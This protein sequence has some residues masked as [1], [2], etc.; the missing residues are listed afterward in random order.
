MT[1]P[2]NAISI[3]PSANESV[4]DVIDRVD[5]NRRP[6]MKGGLGA[7]T[8][9][10]FG[11][12][13]LL[14]AVRGA[15]AATPAPVGGIG[16]SSIA[17][18][19]APG[20]FDGVKVLS[21]YTAKIFSAWGDPIGHA[22]GSP[23]LDPNL[24]Q[25]EANQNKQDGMHHDGMHFFAFPTIGAGGVSN[26]RGLLV[27]NHEYT[28]EGI[29]RNELTPGSTPQNINRVRTSQA[30]HGVSVKEV[31]KV[32]GHWIVQRPSPFARRLTVNTPIKSTGPAAGHALMKTAYINENGSPDG[33]PSGTSVKGTLNNCAHGFTPW[34]TYLTCEENFN[35]YFAST[36]APLA[37]TP[38]EY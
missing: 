34:G 6:F 28:D 9:T 10:A 4:R 20:M 8:L 13:A 22:S 19:L 1:H 2:V 25:T 29:L 18:S 37:R 38:L 27:T 32:A 21:G 7:A 12:E 11:G 30:G 15:Y 31:R 33:D 3:N 24:P 26:E 23:Q 36:E 5:T 35:G 14:G 16:F 17:A